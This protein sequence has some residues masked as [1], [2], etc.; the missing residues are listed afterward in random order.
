MENQP[1]SLLD[2]ASG[3]NYPNQ[4]IIATASLGRNVLE[5]KTSSPRN[6]TRFDSSLAWKTDVDSIKRYELIDLR[7]KFAN[8]KAILFEG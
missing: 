3:L 5:T 6:T 4:K 1:F 7:G 8:E 2:V